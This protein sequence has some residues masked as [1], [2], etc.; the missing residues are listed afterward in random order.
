[1]TRKVSSQAGQVR[2]LEPGLGLSRRVRSQAGQ[3]TSIFTLL[4]TN[5]K[6]VEQDEHLS[7]QGLSSIPAMRIS[8]Q[9]GQDIFSAIQSRRVGLWSTRTTAE[10][11]TQLISPNLRGIML[12]QFG[13]LTVG[14]AWRDSTVKGSSV[15]G[16][17]SCS[18]IQT[19][20]VQPRRG[21]PMIRIPLGMK[22]NGKSSST[23]NALAISSTAFFAPIWSLAVDGIGIK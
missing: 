19:P 23:P 3:D 6:I 18:A 7:P 16:G 12:S 10:Q 9:S 14:G 1:V 20:R 4:E 13:Q 15:A 22:V 11:T 17:M 21:G 2:F 8:E 5:L